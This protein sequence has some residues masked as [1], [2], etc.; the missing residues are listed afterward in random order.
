MKHDNVLSDVFYNV[1]P[2]KIIGKKLIEYENWQTERLADTGNL[3]GPQPNL[4]L[5]FEDGYYME[6][7]E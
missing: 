3:S 1:E 6:K 7:K 2:E 4:T 5:I